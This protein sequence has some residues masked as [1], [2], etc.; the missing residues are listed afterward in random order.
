MPGLVFPPHADSS[1]VDHHSQETS[2]FYGNQRLDWASGPYFLLAFVVRNTSFLAGL[3]SRREMPGYC[4]DDGPLYFLL[5]QVPLQIHKV[6]V[7]SFHDPYSLDDDII[8]IADTCWKDPFQSPTMFCPQE[9]PATCV[10]GLSGK[11]G[12]LNGIGT[13]KKSYLTSYNG[14]SKVAYQGYTGCDIFQ[15]SKQVQVFGARDDDIIQIADT[16]WKVPFSRL[17]CS[18]HKKN[19]PIVYRTISDFKWSPDLRESMEE[20]CLMLGVKFTMPQRYVSHRW[21]SVYDVTMDTLRMFDAF[22]IFYYSWVISLDFDKVKYLP[23]VVEV[24]HRLKVPKESRQRINDIMTHLLK[25]FISYSLPEFTPGS[26]SKESGPQFCLT[27]LELKK[28]NLTKDGKDRKRR[29][30][31]KL[32]VDRKSIKLILGLY[33][34]VLPMLKEFVVL[35][36]MKE[37]LIHQLHERQMDLVKEFFLCFV[38]PEV[39]VEASSGSKLKAIDVT[40]SKNLM[41]REQIFLGSKARNLVSSSSAGDYTVKCFLDQVI[42]AYKSCGKTLTDKLPL[43]NKFIRSVAAIHPDAGHSSVLK[44]LLNLPKLA[45]NV[46]DDEE[47]YDR[48]C[49]RF[50]VDQLKDI[51]DEERIDHWWGNPALSEKYPSLT[52]MVKAVLCCFHGPQVEA[53]FSSMTDIIDNKSNRLNAT[54]FSAIQTVRYELSASGKTAVQYFQK[55][56]FLHEKI[57]VNLCKNM[58]SVYFL[59]NYTLE[60]KRK[61]T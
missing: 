60:L 13:Q 25:T 2:S 42:E 35:F 14:T 27:S 46:L 31:E 17:Q 21:L 38:K 24:Y 58:V 15:M 23:V 43:T 1:P 53:S 61:K 32:F 4:D 19:Q 37:P 12:V 39:V 29:I 7:L 54:T 34:S 8:Q 10:T 50:Q 5:Q 33:S 48:D 28:K 16:C 36:E 45:T 30:V 6:P 47:P 40:S 20:I 41:S 49:R 52:R 56:D 26:R 3:I 18:F 59:R 22:A 9:K 51:E 55:K 44:L 57:D 11:D